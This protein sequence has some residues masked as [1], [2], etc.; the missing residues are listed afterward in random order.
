MRNLVI[1]YYN[2]RFGDNINSAYI[3]LIRE[4]GEIALAIEKENADQAKLIFQWLGVR[5]SQKISLINVNLNPSNG[6]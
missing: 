6:I 3:H 2:K 5:I 1:S 4:I